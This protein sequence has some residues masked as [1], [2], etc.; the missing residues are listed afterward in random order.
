MKRSALVLV[1][2]T[3][4]LGACQGSDKTAGA[5][6]AAGEILPGSASDAMLPYDTVKSQAPLAPKV[7]ASG[8]EGA[9]DGKGNATPDARAASDSAPDSATVASSDVRPSE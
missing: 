5:G 6:T 1:A 9:K 7:E 4:A 2:G 3:L 8:K